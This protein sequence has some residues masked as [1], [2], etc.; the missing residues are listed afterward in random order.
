ME[1][2]VAIV[3]LAGGA[4]LSLVVTDKYQVSHMMAA[5]LIT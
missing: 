3:N 5:M 4:I 2:I 1:V